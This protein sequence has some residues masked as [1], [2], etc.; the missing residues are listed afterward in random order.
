MWLSIV[1]CVFGF[2]AILHGQCA[3]ITPR[4]RVDTASQL[5]VL[6][7]M[8]CYVC[9]VQ[10][11]LDQSLSAMPAGVVVSSKGPCL[12]AAVPLLYW[13]IVRVTPYM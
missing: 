1:E 12:L 2:Q 8:P 7:C 10:L 9:V 4:L 6:T 3:A 13:P 11:V 5:S